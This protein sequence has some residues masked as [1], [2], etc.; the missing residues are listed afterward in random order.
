MTRRRAWW[1]HGHG[2]GFLAGG[3]AGAVEAPV[4]AVLS[5][6]RLVVV[7][8][9][10]SPLGRWAIRKVAR[11]WDK[12]FPETNSYFCAVLLHEVLACQCACAYE[13][14]REGGG[15]VRGISF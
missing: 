11:V 6:G 12:M 1:G 13:R 5:G 4:G 9:S 8:W 2:S 10:S 15:G 7:W 3:E 14:D